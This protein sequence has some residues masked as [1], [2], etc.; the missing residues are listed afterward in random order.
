M[1]DTVC[2][3]Y[4]G[5]FNGCVIYNGRSPSLFRPSTEKQNCVLATG[6]LWD[7][8]KHIKLLLAHKHRV[9]VTIAGAAEHPDK[10]LDGPTDL[11]CEGNL[12]ICGEQDEDQLR[13]LYSSC[14][15]YAATSRYEP[16]GLAPV[17]AALSKCAL[18]ANDIPSFR[19][20]WGDSALFFR[21]NDADALANAIA[22]FAENPPLRR[23]YAE[24]AYERAR[25]RFNS[26]RMV[27]EYED[28]YKILVS[29]GRVHEYAAAA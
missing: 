22:R 10:S 27:D 13:Q 1:L 26:Q 23:L 29:G 18:I 20:L 9:P 12:T 8:A 21:R 28:L 7:E 6:R 14:S 3:H 25:A 4:P 24:E 16:F 19:E 11:S 5:Q 17:E 15:I 2:E